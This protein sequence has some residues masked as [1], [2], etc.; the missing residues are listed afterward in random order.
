MARSS[1]LPHWPCVT[2]P[3]VDLT[4]RF[5]MITGGSVVLI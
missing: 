3:D 1:W 2:V 4:G 5:A